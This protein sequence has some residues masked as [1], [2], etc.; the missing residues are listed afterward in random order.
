MARTHQRGGPK[1][2]A[3]NGGNHSRERGQGRRK[4][5]IPWGANG[6]T[7]EGSGP[8]A[9]RTVKC[10]IEE[11]EK[12]CG[13]C[14]RPRCLRKVQGPGAP[15]QIKGGKSRPLRMGNDQDDGHGAR[16]FLNQRRVQLAWVWCNE[17]EKGGRG[18]A[19]RKGERQRALGRLLHGGQVRGGSTY[20][21]RRKTRFDSSR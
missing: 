12:G 5:E 2:R 19:G 16:Q 8:S 9:R 11:R 20:I 3:V 4:A 18:R 15:N 7:R 6:G 13:L 21:A 14:G 10:W 1:G 17:W